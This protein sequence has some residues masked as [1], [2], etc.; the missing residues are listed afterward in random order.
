[1][2]VK[3]LKCQYSLAL[4]FYFQNLPWGNSA[5]QSKSCTFLQNIENHSYKKRDKAIVNYVTTLLRNTAMPLRLWLII[6]KDVFYN[7]KAK[8]WKYVISYICLTKKTRGRVIKIVTKVA[9]S[10]RGNI[11]IFWTMLD[12]RSQILNLAVFSPCHVAYHPTVNSSF[13]QS[14]GNKFNLITS[15]FPLVISVGNLDCAWDVLAS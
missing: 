7:A 10:A 13:P 14:D 6:W 8:W 5:K 3:S 15:S 9:I 4:S 11:T 1:M 2:C 12:K